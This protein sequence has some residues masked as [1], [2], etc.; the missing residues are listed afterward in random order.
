VWVCIIKA[1]KEKAMTNM[2][3]P[4][5]KINYLNELKLIVLTVPSQ[6]GKQTS[7]IPRDLQHG[8]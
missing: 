1:G 8:V 2:N 6:N 3:W 4:L 5:R 7:G